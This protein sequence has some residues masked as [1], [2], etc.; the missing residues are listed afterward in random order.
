M[1][2]RWS[3]WLLL[4]LQQQH[5]PLTRAVSAGCPCCALSLCISCDGC[6]LLGLSLRIQRWRRLL[7]ALHTGAQAP[8]H[9]ELQLLLLPQLLGRQCSQR[10]GGLPCALRH[11][12]SCY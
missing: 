7:C 9:I 2:L 5:C 1:L 3:H 6:R 8:Q 11:P 10:H 12:C 4:L